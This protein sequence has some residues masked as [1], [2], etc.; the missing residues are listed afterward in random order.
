MSALI[1]KIKNVYKTADSLKGHTLKNKTGTHGGLY[2][3]F[4]LKTRF[5][6]CP[7]IGFYGLLIVQNLYHP[8]L[9]ED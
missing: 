2:R 7:N 3:L 8:R 9:G 5:R 4:G 1:F 6:W